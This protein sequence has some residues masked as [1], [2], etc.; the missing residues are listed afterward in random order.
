MDNVGLYNRFGVPAAN[1]YWEDYFEGVEGA[2]ESRSKSKD[3]KDAKER[4]CR[5][6][7]LS[8]GNEKVHLIHDSLDDDYAYERAKIVNEC[9]GWYLVLYWAISMDRKTYLQEF[10]EKQKYEEY[11]RARYEEIVDL[12]NSIYYELNY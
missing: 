5:E 2:T 8:E 7:D 11:N 9:Y 12:Q 6:R 10:V 1:R 4:I 3:S